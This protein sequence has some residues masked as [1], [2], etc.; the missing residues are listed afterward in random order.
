MTEIEKQ[1]PLDKAARPF[2]LT[3]KEI[4]LVFH[5]LRTGNVV[6]AAIE[7]GYSEKSAKNAH[8]VLRKE[9]VA[10]FLRAQVQKRFDDERME[11]GEILARL[12][13]IGRMD[14]R[15]LFREDG[16]YVPMAELDEGTAACL[17]AYETELEFHDDGAPPTMIR[18]VKFAD[19]VPALKILAQVNQLL[20]PEQAQMNVFIDLDSRMDQARRRR[21]EQ[22]AKEQ[23][24]KSNQV[25]SEQ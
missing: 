6:K 17:R 5:Y 20:A 21:A 4:D 15:K 14:P 3:M 10:T 8:R 7:A 1:F 18:K 9:N 16:S 24:G 19:P 23:G 13:R 2:G 11:N 25:V 12:A 22:V